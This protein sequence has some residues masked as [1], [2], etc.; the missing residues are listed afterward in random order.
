MN[1]NV[2]VNVN[3]DVDVDVKR[4]LNEISVMLV[5]A[6]EENKQGR[7]EGRGEPMLKS[8]G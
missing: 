2:N 6:L 8:W 1:V 5:G 4:E 3:V 7:K